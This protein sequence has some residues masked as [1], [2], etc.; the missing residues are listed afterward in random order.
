MLISNIDLSISS[1][2]RTITITDKTGYGISGYGSNQSPAGKREASSSGTDIQTT[3][4]VLTSP[5]LETYTFNLTASQAY[6]ATLNG[7]SITNVDLGYAID[8]DI[9]EGIWTVTYTTFFGSNTPTIGVTNGSTTV[10]YNIAGSEA[11]DTF[12][13]TAVL[14]TTASGTPVYYNISSIN[15]ST[16]VIT[17]ATAYASTTNASYSDYHVGYKATDYLPIV[18][19]IKNC[20]DAKVAALPNSPCPCKDKQVN[21]LMSNYLL[22]DA[23]F[24][25]A[26]NQN[27]TKANYIYDILS[28]YCSDSDCKCNG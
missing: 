10:T 28:N 27:Q 9:E 16:G 4:I 15:T 5:S 24:I 12:R 13:G 20:L 6:N 23:M 7:Y 26:A 22:Y 18:K 1:D 11:N 14:K 21:T 17:L 3:Q 19:T 2:W 8:E 25:N